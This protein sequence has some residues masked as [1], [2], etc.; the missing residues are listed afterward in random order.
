MKV[1]SENNTTA[2]IVC[3]AL[4]QF[5]DW[6]LVTLGGNPDPHENGATNPCANI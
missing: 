3:V 5:G 1:V 2:T 4:T 6:H